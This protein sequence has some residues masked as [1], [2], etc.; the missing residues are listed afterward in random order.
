MPDRLQRFDERIGQPLRELVQRYQAAGGIRGR[1]GR[2]PPAV[3]E[4]DAAER[5]PRRPDRPEL[6]QQLR[7]NRRRGQLSTVRQHRKPVVQAAGPRRVVAAEDI[8]FRGDQPAQAAQQ[9]GAAVQSDQRIVIRDLHAA[10]EIG[11]I[12]IREHAGIGAQ[13]LGG[14][15]S[16]ESA[17]RE[18]GEAGK[19]Q[20]FRAAYG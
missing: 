16:R 14:W 6:L 15:N 19:P 4:R 12:K 17:A 8:R 18:H 2:M 7:Q 3:A 1:H 10:L 11:N 9:V 13:R 20:S 5:Q